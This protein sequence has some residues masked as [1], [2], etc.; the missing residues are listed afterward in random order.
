M[1]RFGIKNNLTFVSF[2]KSGA[3]SAVDHSYMT[4]F[5]RVHSVCPFRWDIDSAVFL[6][7]YRLIY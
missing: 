6:S 7:S 4:V 5:V 3:H 2:K 1:Q